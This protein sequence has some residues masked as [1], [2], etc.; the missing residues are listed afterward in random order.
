MDIATKQDIEKIIR[1]SISGLKEDLLKEMKEY[2]QPP[3]EWMTA[4][5]IMKEMGWS[6][7]TFDKYRH[8]I[9][10][11]KIGKKLLIRKRDFNTWLEQKF[12]E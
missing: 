4:Q 9:P 2:L 8:E 11:R 6:R 3:D 7:R 10:L 5:D 12:N 1:R